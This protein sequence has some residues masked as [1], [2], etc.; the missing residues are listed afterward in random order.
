MGRLCEA[1]RRRNARSHMLYGSFIGTR[2]DQRRGAKENKRRMNS[3]YNETQINLRHAESRK[4][5]V[6]LSS[7]V[8]RSVGV[9]S[10]GCTH[11]R[12]RR[13]RQAPTAITRPHIRPL[14]RDMST[15]TRNFNDPSIR[16]SSTSDPLVAV[17]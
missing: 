2:G 12:R 8:Y 10:T 6:A 7:Y 15:R 3:D 1:D 17:L 4:R 14:F 11:R 9:S 16:A 13:L 5:A